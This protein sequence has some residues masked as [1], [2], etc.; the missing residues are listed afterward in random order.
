MTPEEWLY[1]S[2]EDERILDDLMQSLKDTISNIKT[3]RI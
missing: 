1:I 3:R 2:P